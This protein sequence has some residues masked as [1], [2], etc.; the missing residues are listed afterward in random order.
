M[1]P[2]IKLTNELALLNKQLRMSQM[3][4]EYH[5]RVENQVRNPHMHMDL[6]RYGGTPYWNN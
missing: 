5:Q 4:N 3:A 1:D 2:F 6:V